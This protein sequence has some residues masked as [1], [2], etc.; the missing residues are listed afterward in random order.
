M[1]PLPSES[2]GNLNAMDSDKRDS[3]ALPVAVRWQDCSKEELWLEVDSLRKDRW[4]L[5]QKLRKIALLARD[6]NGLA[7]RRLR[8]ISDLTSDYMNPFY[9]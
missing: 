6:L 4:A 8:D 7:E 2:G 1:V 5:Y 9:D 3:D